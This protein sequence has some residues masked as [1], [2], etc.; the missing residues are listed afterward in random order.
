[1]IVPYYQPKVSLITGE[2]VGFE[3]LLRW[4][5]PILGIQSPKTIWEAFSDPV[6]SIAI[7]HRMRRM[8]LADMK[9]WTKR[10]VTFGAVAINVSAAEFTRGDFAKHILDSLETAGL[11]TDVLELEVT[12][13]VFLGDGAG[14]I[15][16]ALSKLSDA[17]I[18]IALDDFG[19][20][21]ASLT[22]L[23][24]FPVGWLKVDRS[25][26]SDMTQS[27]ESASIVGTV[28]ELSHS[29]EIGVVAEG[30]ETMEQLDMLKAWNCEVG[31]GYLFGKPMDAD[32]VP[33]L[34]ATW[35]FPQK[36]EYRRA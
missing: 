22:H 35:S 18:A 19:T 25:F 12:E 26:I 21:Y 20:G 4:R 16:E 11:P 10:G 24:Q 28:I 9:E 17:G 27:R 32:L 33:G 3:A 15:G 31:Q 36:K 5:D 2:V 30:I 23:R 14:D 8:V 13:T 29:L 7:G 6:L 1:M 34:L